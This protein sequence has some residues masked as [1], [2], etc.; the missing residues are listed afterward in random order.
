VSRVAARQGAD[1][2]LVRDYYDTYWAAPTQPRYELGEVLAGLLERHVDTST[3]CLDVGCGAGQ[4]YG[5]WV[6]RRAGAYSG[7]DVSEKAVELA[8]GSG[9]D[10]EV[11]EDAAALPFEDESFDVAICIEVFEHLFSP[12]KAAA[13]ICRVLR[14]GGTLIAS[15]PNAAYW[16][17]RANLLFGLWNPLGDAL[18]V[19]QP[20]RDPHIRFFTP[21]TMSRMLSHSGFSSIE[22]KAHGGCFLDHLTS[23]PTNF[24]VSPIYQRAE[25]RFPSLLGATIHAVATR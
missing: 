20:W 8:R 17:L 5:Q 9:L 21:Q 11:I 13:E 14:P 15:A 7:V 3:R 12:D 19:E 16:R 2:T 23:R 1:A 6:N 24:G 10:A 18:A 25:A 4:T 22:T